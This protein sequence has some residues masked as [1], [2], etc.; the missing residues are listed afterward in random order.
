MMRVQKKM[1]QRKT[2]KVRVGRKKVET[3]KTKRIRMI[4]TG[5]AQTH[6]LWGQWFAALFCLLYKI[7]VVAV[8]VSFFMCGW[9]ALNSDSV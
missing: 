9:V 6:S 4:S 3:M 5:N 1:V 8:R 2:R 7:A